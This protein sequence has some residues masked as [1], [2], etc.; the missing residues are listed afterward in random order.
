MHIL[1]G[2]KDPLSD[3]AAIKATA[4]NEVGE[5]FMEKGQWDEALVH[6]SK[7]FSRTHA[8]AVINSMARKRTKPSTQLALRYRSATVSV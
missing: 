8:Y 5:Y 6:F 7:V 4:A 1:D 3:N 2:L